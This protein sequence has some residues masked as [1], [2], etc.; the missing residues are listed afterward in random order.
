MEDLGRGGV[1]LSMK[2]L[3][4][5]GLFNPSDLNSIDNYHIHPPLSDSLCALQWYRMEGVLLLLKEVGCAQ[6]RI[7]QFVL[8]D[9][10]KS[11]QLY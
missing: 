6:T 11:N 5:G 8:E 4:R 2:D 1:K 10:V 9:N 7:H 3:G